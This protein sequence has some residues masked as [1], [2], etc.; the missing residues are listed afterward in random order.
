MAASW[1]LKRCCST[2]VTETTKGTRWQR[3]INSRAGVWCRSLLSDYKEACRE[4]V[5]GARERPLKASLYLG[6]LG[7]VYAC[8]YTN[9]DDASF[10]SSLRETSNRLALLSP[11]IRNGTSDGHVQTL[12]K[13]R[14]EGRLRY[15]SLGIAS[16][17]YYT[18]Y[19]SE[20]SLYEA[21]CSAISVPWAELPKRVLDV[22][23]TGRWWVLDHKMKDFD[24]NEE[25]FKH[26]PPALVAAVPSSPQITERNER[27]HQESW[28]AVVMEDESDELDGVQKPMDTPV[29]GIERNTINKS[30]TS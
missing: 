16:L 7:G 9:P 18:D 12:V 20:S 11:W 22:G 27:M 21:S 25:E 14:N 26:L 10:E 19:D 29:K 3:L 2:T 17:T 15:A 24:I 13:L 28:K 23:F 6:L 30:Q 4:A 8:H 5:L 1:L